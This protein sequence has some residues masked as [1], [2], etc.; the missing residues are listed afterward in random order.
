[1]R[2][3]R[4]IH[5]FPE[6]PI[7]REYDALRRAITEALM[8]PCLKHLQATTGE[9]T[10]IAQVVFNRLSEKMFEIKFLDQEKI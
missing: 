10:T 7:C 2:A 8:L 1:M 5:S 6:K 4:K 3:I 9:A